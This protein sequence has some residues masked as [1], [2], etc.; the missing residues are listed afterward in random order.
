MT[1][2]QEFKLL[3]KNWKAYTE[4]KESIGTIDSGGKDMDTLSSDLFNFIKS[5]KK[6]TNKQQIIDFIKSNFEIFGLINKGNQKKIDSLLNNKIPDQPFVSDLPNK[7]IEKLAKDITNAIFQ[8]YSSEHYTDISSDTKDSLKKKGKKFVPG[9]TDAEMADIAKIMAAL[10]IAKIAAGAVESAFT[11]GSILGA[12]KSA[13]TG[14]KTAGDIVSAI[15]NNP[16]GIAKKLALGGA[17]TALLSAGAAGVYYL[18]KGVTGKEQKDLT[19]AEKKQLEQLQNDPKYKEFLKKAAELEAKRKKGR[20]TSSHKRAKKFGHPNQVDVGLNNLPNL[21]GN[22]TTIGNIQHNLKG[23]QK[24]FADQ[25]L[26]L[27]PSIGIGTPLM[28]MAIISA[29][30]KESDYKPISEGAVYSF[31]RIKRNKKNDH[32]PNRFHKRFEE[33]GLPPPTDKQIKAVSGGGTNGV[34]LFNI[35]YGYQN[36]QLDERLT[37]QTHPLLVNGKINPDLYDI[38]LAGWKYRGRGA[39]GVTFKSTYKNAA[40]KAGLDF[41]DIEKRIMELDEKN[42]GSSGQ[43]PLPA[44]LAIQLNLGYL[45]STN[46]TYYKIYGDP[47]SIED[48][49]EIATRMIGGN[50]SSGHLV[51]HYNRSIEYLKKNFRFSEQG[52]KYMYAAA[53]PGLPGEPEDVSESKR[54]TIKII[55]DG[56]NNA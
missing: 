38:K 39:I 12:V 37:K 35:A 4:I 52:Q 48:A 21:K 33:H 2:D 19:D 49:V 31:A 7:E 10:G 26:K 8:A 1:K 25:L 27:L 15:K 46:R 16:G 55:K 23:S 22:V 41:K 32:V 45:K 28:Q 30:G 43:D 9:A 13:F 50:Y 53:V 44:D 40:S 18:Y 17:V 24:E 6:N 56:N 11:K 5:N 54:K 36:Y 42:R 51:N 14:G 34:A 20:K 29:V 3:F 47:Q